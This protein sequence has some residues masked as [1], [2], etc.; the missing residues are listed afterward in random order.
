[1]ERQMQVEIK[2]LCEC[3]NTFW[4][5]CLGTEKITIC[6]TCTQGIIVQATKIFGE[7]VIVNVP[8]LQV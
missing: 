5:R 4:V 6:R 8:T 1:M 2:V 3:G 7:E